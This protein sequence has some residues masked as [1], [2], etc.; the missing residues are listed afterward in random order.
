[1]SLLLQLSP[2]V[3]Q[4]RIEMGLTQVALAS[5]CGLSRSTINQLENGSLKDI[6]VRRL[7]LVGDALGINVFGAPHARASRKSSDSAVAARSA[8]VSYKRSLPPAVLV[9]TL[10]T[11]Q[12]P[13]AFVAH[14]ATLLDELPMSLLAAVVEEVSK[15]KSLDRKTVWSSVR[16]LATDLHSNRA[17]LR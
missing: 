12:A 11:G 17:V 9:K 10:A 16:K 13:D 15:K 7:Q 6:S 4:R 5:L 3:R 1:M 2:L 8:S 14:I